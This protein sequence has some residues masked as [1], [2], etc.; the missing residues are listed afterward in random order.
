MQKF[1]RLARIGFYI[2]LFGVLAQLVH[3]LLRMPYGMHKLLESG[4]TVLL[5]AGL[6]FSVWALLVGSDAKVSFKEGRIYY[7]LAGLSIVAVVI[8]GSLGGF[9]SQW[10]TSLLNFCSRH[11][12]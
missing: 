10:V 6:A 8:D 9:L 3:S 5:I 1:A 2:T 7:A 4:E 12:H 11:L